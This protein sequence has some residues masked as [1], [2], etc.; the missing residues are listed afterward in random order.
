MTEF[1]RDILKNLP[2]GESLS[3]GQIGGK[4]YPTVGGYAVS[5]ALKKLAIDG[6]V[7]VK[8]NRGRNQN[9]WTKLKEAPAIRDK[10]IPGTVKIKGVTLAA[11]DFGAA[12]A[13]LKAAADRRAQG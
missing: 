5:S 4:L 6:Y 12:G 13:N 8:Y 9:L 2:M 10:T 11:P 7:A 3:C 1:Q